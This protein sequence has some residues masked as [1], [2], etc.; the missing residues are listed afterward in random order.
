MPAS[1]ADSQASESYE[2]RSTHTPLPVPRTR[3]EQSAAPSPGGRHPDYR[4]NPSQCQ[5]T[6][7]APPSSCH[8]DRNGGIHSEI[9]AFAQPRPSSPVGRVHA[10]G[11]CLPALRVAGPPLWEPRPRG[12]PPASIGAWPFRCFG[13]ST[14]EAIRAHPRLPLPSPVLRW[15]HCRS[16]PRPSPAS[17]AV[18]CSAGASLP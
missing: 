10:E 2:M 17:L 1:P 14:A 7:T 18:P 13:S 11:E 12:D 15:F 16:H 3:R 9:G 6:P 4:P 5:T 8:S